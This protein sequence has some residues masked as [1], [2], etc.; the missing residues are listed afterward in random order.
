MK[1]LKKIILALT[2]SCMVGTSLVGCS[3]LGNAT[4]ETTEEPQAEQTEQTETE[5]EEQQAEPETTEPETQEQ[6][7][8]EQTAQPQT[9][10][11]SGGA[12]TPGTNMSEAGQIPLNEKYAGSLIPK[13]SAWFAFTTGSEPTIYNITFVNTSADQD[14]RLSGDVYT[15]YGDKI[16][17]GSYDAMRDGKPVTIK[18]DKL[19]TNTTYY[20]CLSSNAFQGQMN[21]TIVVKPVDEQPETYNEYRWD[22]R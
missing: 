4:K 1:N 14:Y 10:E 22:N 18:A 3:L 15:E 13:E 6:T 21:Y 20:V 17:Y 7:T 5:P 11:Q 12:I 2:I 16:F 9:N 8:Q 19:E